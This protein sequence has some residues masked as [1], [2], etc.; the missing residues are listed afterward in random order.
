VPIILGGDTA[1]VEGFI[2][3]PSIDPKLV[4]EVYDFSDMIN[5]SEVSDTTN[6]SDVSE[7][8]DYYNGRNAALIAKLARIHFSET[9]RAMNL[10][11]AN[12]LQGRF[13]R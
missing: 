7:F 10:A 5:N 4:T 12:D 8:A 6:N 11:R 3:S 9:E 2:G 1:L 13:R